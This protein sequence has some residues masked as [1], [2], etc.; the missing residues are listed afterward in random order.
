LKILYQT[1]VNPLRQRE[2]DI[3]KS[4]W[5][6]LGVSVELKAVQSGVFF[7]SDVG[8]PDTAAKFYADIEMFTNNMESPDPT[9]Y[10]QSWTTKQ[11]NSKAN[12]WRG[13][14]YERYSNPEYDNLFEQLQKEADPAKRNEIA[15][16]MNDILISDVVIIPLVARTS[17]T[18]GKAKN[19]TGNIANSWDSE[20]WNIADWVRTGS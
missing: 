1:T 5:E 9:N 13:N 20:L 14:N 4:G 11:I 15:I 2:Q 6:Q 7:S 3:V 10:L 17:P 12:E 8:N 18:S 16:K 19:I